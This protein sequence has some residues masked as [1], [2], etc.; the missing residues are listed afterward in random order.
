MM[1]LPS[2]DYHYCDN[3]LIIMSITDVAARIK[4]SQDTHMIWATV[5]ITTQLVI[6]SLIRGIF[7]CK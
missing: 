3:T 1:I 2:A 6:L 5:L 4:K 7:G